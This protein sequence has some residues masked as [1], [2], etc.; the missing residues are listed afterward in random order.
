[1]KQIRNNSVNSYSNLKI[2]KELCRRLSKFV[3][4][5]LK[6][7]EIKSG[8]S[9]KIEVVQNEIR[10]KVESV[11]RIE[12]ELEVNEEVLMSNEEHIQRLYLFIEHVAI[13]FRK[14]NYDELDRVFKEINL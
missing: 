13:N 6:F 10:K 1:M 8:D 2:Y 14:E 11:N 3:Y 9:E 4:R 5:I 7:C 12:K